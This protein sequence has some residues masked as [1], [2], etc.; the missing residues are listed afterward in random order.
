MKSVEEIKEYFESHCCAN[1]IP[2][3]LI[4]GFLY[5]IG[6]E[7]ANIMND[8]PVCAEEG[9]INIS[10]MCFQRWFNDIP[11]G[12]IWDNNELYPRRYSEEEIREAYFLVAEDNTVFESEEEVIGVADDFMMHLGL[13]GKSANKDQ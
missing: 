12:D 7:Y 13:T 2:H 1:G 5:G 10:Y 8:V 6:G 3:A 11:E 4:S 9:K